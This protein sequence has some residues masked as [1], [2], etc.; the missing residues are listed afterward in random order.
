MQRRKQ[1]IPYPGKT[2]HYIILKVLQ[3]YRPIVPRATHSKIACK[4]EAC[5][6]ADPADRTKSA[7]EL[8]QFGSFQAECDEAESTKCAPERVQALEKYDR[9]LQNSFELKSVSRN[10]KEALQRIEDEHALT[11]ACTSQALQRIGRLPAEFEELK[12][13]SAK[14]LDEILSEIG[15]DPY[16]DTFQEAGISLACHLKVIDNDFLEKDLGVKN[17]IHRRVML[18]T[19][20]NSSRSGMVSGSNRSLP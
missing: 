7:V 1:W 10:M 16:L 5:D 3:G 4:I 2:F 12:R 8:A 14:D 17:K 9:L 13:A 15:M 18:R 6:S 19:F 11:R 20:H